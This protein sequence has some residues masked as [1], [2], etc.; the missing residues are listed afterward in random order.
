MDDPNPS[1]GTYLER[2]TPEKRQRDAERLSSLMT[3]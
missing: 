2:I 1:V 3:R